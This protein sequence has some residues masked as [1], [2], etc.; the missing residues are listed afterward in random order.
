MSRELSGLVRELRRRSGL[1]QEQ[2]AERSGLSLRTITRWET[3]AGRPPRVSSLMLLADALGLGDEDRQRLLSSGGA[4]ADERTPVESVSGRSF[5]PRDLADFTARQG[6]LE[7]LLR[8]TA[9]TGGS[10]VTVAVIDGMAGVGKTALAVRAAHL[11]A[12]GYPDGQFF[13]DLHGFTPGRD[14]VTP[15]GALDGLLRA[16][17]VPPGQIPEELDQ[18]AGLWRSQLSD[19]RALVLLDNAADAAQVRP[20]LPGGAGCLALVTSRRRLSAVDGAMSVSLDVLAPGEAAE[21]FA[22]VVG[23]DRCGAAPQGVA[24][25]VA[26]CGYLPLAIRLAAARLVHR[27]AWTVEHLAER[28][29]RETRRPA[30]PAEDDDR[31][32][33]AAFALSY[34]GLAPSQQRLFRLLGL[35]PGDEVDAYCAAALADLSLHQA[36][37]LL[38]DLVDHHLLEQPAPGRYAFHDLI[39]RHAEA[40]ALATESEEERHAALTRLFDHFLYT[41]SVATA[42]LDPAEQARHARVRRPT[43]PAV[44]LVDAAAAQAWL[45][46]EH[47]N[48]LAA[49]RHAADGSW[50]AHVTGLS[51][52]LW[53]HLDTQARY[54][55]AEELHRRAVLAARRLSDPSAESYALVNLGIVQ[56]RTGRYQ[57][58][59]ACQQEALT[60]IRD[61]P[62]RPREGDAE[63]NLGIAYWL[64]G[65]LAEAADHYSRALA[66][67]RRIGDDTGESRVL[68]N[69]GVVRAR[70][71]RY[72]EA[73]DLQQQALVIFRRIND[74]VGEAGAL[75]LLGNVHQRTGRY[76]RAVDRQRQ[77][78]AVFRE[79]GHLVGEA[80]A[81][82]SLGLVH[83]A[84]GHHRQAIEH[85]RRALDIFCR[86]GYR[87]GEVEATNGLGESHRCAGEPS[88]ALEL[89]RTALDLAGEDG[90]VYEQARAHRGLAAAHHALG[91]SDHALRHRQHARQLFTRLGV[92]EADE[93]DDA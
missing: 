88:R 44:D 28:L 87:V 19:K 73:A 85:H 61:L 81:L 21:L 33:S 5:L 42:L 50:P 23:D 29:R 86:V 43:T 93:T 38:E 70:T 77:A 72:E 25:I 9:A 4:P 35:N 54:A 60:L 69:L 51:T 27:P 20:L 15:A 30:E 31:S 7:R 10:A 45:D 36:D 52:V 78:L 57:Q 67:F 2:L 34:R 26:L 74:R 79:T 6:D 49:A 64:T 1:T 89:H 8:S 48:L 62:D 83:C 53:G 82:Q 16:L 24:E 80:C 46:A 17:G 90:D 3:R 91:Q 63:G 13:L 18:Q 55:D 76:D 65:C 47:A 12:D 32:V 75:H 71:G 22:R 41:A 37:D 92:P 56:L 14:P 40:T 66:V 84:T 11:L 58:G 39:R 68:S 59:I